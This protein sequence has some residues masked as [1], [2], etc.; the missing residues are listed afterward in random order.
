[1]Q[2]SSERRHLDCGFDFGM[3]Y[4]SVG[5]GYIEVHHVLPLHASGPVLTRLT[6]LVLLCSNCHRMIHRSSAWLSP[7]ELRSRLNR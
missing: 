3:T 4:G 5:Q 7:D 2:S 6:D 1:M